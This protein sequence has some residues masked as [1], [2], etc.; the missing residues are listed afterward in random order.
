MRVMRQRACLAEVPVVRSLEA[1]AAGD[2]ASGMR[3]AECFFAL[4]LGSR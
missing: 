4:D 2:S 1:A 3:S